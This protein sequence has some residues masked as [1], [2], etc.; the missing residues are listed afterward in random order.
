MSLGSVLADEL[1]LALDAFYDR[2]SENQNTR[3][4]FRSK[5]D[6]AHAREAQQRHW[7]VFPKNALDPDYIKRIQTIGEVHAK[8]G[9][10]PRWY[11]G[12]YAIVLSH[13]T[14]A[15]VRDQAPKGGLLALGKA[16]IGPSRAEVAQ[17][18]SETVSALIKAALLEIDLTISVYLE[19]AQKRHDQERQESIDGER[20]YVMA[21][22]GS[23]IARI[24]KGDL[25][26]KIDNTVPLPYKPLA[27][28]L[29][30][31]TAS[32]GGVIQ[33]SKETLAALAD[34]TESISDKSHD[35]SSHTQEQSRAIASIAVAVSQITETVRGTA[36]L[37]DRAARSASRCA[38]SA[39]AANALALKSETAMT[40][41][42]K[43]SSDINEIA[44]AVDGVAN[45]TNLLA[46][47]AG[48]EAARAGE[49]GKGFSVLAHEIRTLAA[50]VSEA[51]QNIRNLVTAV[52]ADILQA[53]DGMRSVR[54]GMDSM[55][56]DVKTTES[57]IADIA[58]AAQEEADTLVE[59]NHGIA[60]Y[61]KEAGH[62]S[63]MTE[64]M[65][66]GLDSIKSLA[67]LMASAMGAFKV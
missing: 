33:H 12:G 36:D 62:T 67:G 55:I 57:H 4:M 58:K 28:D 49:A 53:E 52:H 65:E 20:A 3:G 14:A 15:F 50:A 24:S 29:N 26:G 30:A 13:V 32:L 61:T 6:I 21:A 16:L 25:T 23:I 5:A 1:P 8:I 46:L 37:S 64:S 34:T 2:V 19:A 40:N 39:Q 31:A 56:H 48:I 38:T 9:L 11:I 44:R 66:I 41:V 60:R 63:A 45:K 47:N 54:T 18:T 10:A 22:F 7:S 43:T 59:I 51:S 17:K 42:R 35:L 27:T